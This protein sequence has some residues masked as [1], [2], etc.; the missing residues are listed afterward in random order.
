VKSGKILE[1]LRAEPNQ[2][3]A[4]PTAQMHS[5]QPN[6][7]PH[8]HS[9][10][11][12]ASSSK[13]PTPK[14]VLKCR[15]PIKPIKPLKA[16]NPSVSSKVSKQNSKLAWRPKVPSILGKTPTRITMVNA[17]VEVASTCDSR[18]FDQVVVV[19][20]RT[21]HVVLSWV[22]DTLSWIGFGVTPPT[23][24]WSTA[25]ASGYVYLW[26]QRLLCLRC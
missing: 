21:Q 16:H 22:M 18:V 13:G 10:R 11:D 19:P 15:Q 6:K 3:E 17:D 26:G 8:V 2:V 1:S 20:E 23:S 25:M 24:F 4:Q 14:P 7:D 5:S 9:H 12:V